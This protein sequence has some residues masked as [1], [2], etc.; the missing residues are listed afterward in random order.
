MRGLNGKRV[1]IT[2]GGSGIGREVS[3]RFGEEGTDVAIFDMNAAGA[4]ETA[5]MIRSAGGKASA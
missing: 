1:V 4:E 2:G 5:E 3:R